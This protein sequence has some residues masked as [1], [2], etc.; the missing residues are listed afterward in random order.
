MIRYIIG[1][2]YIIDGIVDEW[3]Y[4]LIHWMYQWSKFFKIYIFVYHQI[5]SKEQENAC[6]MQEKPWRHYDTHCTWQGYFYANHAS[7]QEKPWRHIA[8]GK[9][10]S[11]FFMQAAKKKDLDDIVMHMAGILL[12]F[13]CKL[14]ERPS[15]HWGAQG[16]DTSALFL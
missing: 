7:C 5:F 13:S 4:M 3:S 14:Q 2:Y 8:K 10:T 9:D 1:Y 15:W 16:K 12:T 6:K 11:T